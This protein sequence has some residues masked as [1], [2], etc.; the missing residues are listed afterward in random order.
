MDYGYSLTPVFA[1]G[2]RETF[3][4]VQVPT[5]YSISAGSYSIA[6]VKLHLLI[7]PNASFCHHAG[8]VG[9]SLLA[10]LVWNSGHLA[11]GH[12]VRRHA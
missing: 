3:S 8:A 12:L 6:R 10:E 11:L 7:S 1:F 9:L 4:N 2:E 5:P